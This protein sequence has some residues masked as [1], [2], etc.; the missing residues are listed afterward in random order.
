MAT[1]KH[2]LKKLVSLLELPFFYSSNYI[3]LPK[4]ETRCSHLTKLFI[5]FRKDGECNKQSSQP[6][7]K[8]QLEE[9]ENQLI[10]VK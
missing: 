2:E 8:P 3:I 7:A 6:S 4:G 10:L 5:T 9:N 1:E